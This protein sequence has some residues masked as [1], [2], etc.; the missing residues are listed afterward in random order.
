MTLS[1]GKNLNSARDRQLHSA[2]LGDMNDD[3]RRDIHNSEV[4]II[5]RSC[6]ARHQGICGT[7]TPAQ[8]SALAKTTSRR[9]Y[10]PFEPIMHGGAE[11]THHANILRGVAKLAKTT[12]DGRQQIVGLQFAPDFLG[13]VFSTQSDVDAE[14]ATE[15]EVC[16][17]PRRSIE[18][19]IG[20]NPELEHMLHQ[21]TLKELDEARDWMLMLG[22]KSA[23]ERVASFLHFVVQH[24][25]P[26]GQLDSKDAVLALPLRR[27][28]M[29]DFLGLTI[30]TVSRQL[31]K[32]K[33]AKV[34]DL[35][36]A[37]S[38]VIL[39]AS[40]LAAATE[41]TQN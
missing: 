31:T 12:A 18:K 27:A 8:L 35:P 2:M 9:V 30:E 6:E 16:S 19:L 11:I 23:G 33:N 15:V 1:L 17:F 20:E 39:D 34:I 7:L 25:N 14:A 38:L 10:A 21:Q 41:T 5:C 26:T 13:R 29:A 32:L 22:R 40:R 28:D 3:G 4:P 37:R 36:D 24:V